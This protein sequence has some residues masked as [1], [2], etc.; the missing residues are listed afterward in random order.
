MIK[1][2]SSKKKKS[3]FQS[4]LFSDH[5]IVHFIAKDL[6]VSGKNFKVQGNGISVYFFS[7]ALDV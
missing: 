6:A 5:L 3:P 4:F 2:L 7:K 1:R